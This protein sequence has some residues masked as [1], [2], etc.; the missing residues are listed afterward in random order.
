MV[1]AIQHEIVAA[2]PTVCPERLPGHTNIFCEIR[3]SDQ[4]AADLWGT[5]SWICLKEQHVESLCSSYLAFSPGA[6]LESRW[7]SYL[8]VLTRLLTRRIQVLLYRF[9]FSMV[10][11]S[12]CLF[13]SNGDISFS[14]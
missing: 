7:C 9:D 11:S 2:S 12:S 14:R 4:K 8:I 1:K 5:T 3:S 6:L 10:V 13:S